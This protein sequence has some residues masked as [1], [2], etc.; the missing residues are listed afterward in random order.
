[1][2]IELKVDPEVLIAKAGELSTEKTAIMGFVDSIKEDMNSLTAVWKS[3]ASDTYQA[4]FKQI[5]DDID[6]ILAIA[7]EHINDLNEA[8]EIYKTAENTAK[9]TGEG[10]PTGILG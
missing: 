5:Y 2:D 4:R 10:L 7:T 1:M 3:E 9:R 8:A 6:N